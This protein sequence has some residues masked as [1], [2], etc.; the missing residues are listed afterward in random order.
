MLRSRSTRGTLALAVGCVASASLGC[1][2]PEGAPPPPAPVPEGAEVTEWEEPEVPEVAPPAVSDELPPSLGDAPAPRVER[3]PAPDTAFA[4][5]E[6]VVA[7]RVVYRVRIGVPG[8]LGEP[9]VDIA[10]PAAELYLDVSVDRLRARFV[11]PG[12]PLHEGAEVRLRGDSPGAYVFD[13]AGGRSLE[14]GA[15]AAW[16]EGGDPRPG[17]RAYV[18]RDTGVDDDDG[19][20]P[21]PLV[22][23]L[24]AEWAG[25]PRS[26]V[27][28][29]CGNAAPIAFRAG[30]YR[31]ERTADV[32]LTLP[33][34]A[35]RADEVGMEAQMQS[36][37]KGWLEL[38][39]F[40]HVLQKPL[41]PEAYGS[42]AVPSFNGRWRST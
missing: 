40:W 10:V 25:V 4:S 39:K 6:P 34:S 13:G 26:S 36:I 37:A 32:P 23:A 16:F 1:A 3:A 38:D 9:F 30:A 24:V 33:R 42:G 20:L 11:G 2:R 15:L 18:R 17:P 21:G 22:C 12:W 8:I 27:G 35:L 29:R 41:H 28:A 19:P 14:P 7:R 5:D 31:A